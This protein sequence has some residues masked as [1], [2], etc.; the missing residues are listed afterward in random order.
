MALTLA[1]RTPVFDRRVAGLSG[2]AIK[3]I[4][5]WAIYRVHRAVG[6][7]LIGMGGISCAE[8]ALEFLL[9]GATAVALGTH[10]FA[11]P[12]APPALIEDLERWCCHN[13]IDDI[14]ELRGMLI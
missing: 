7:P 13:E 9:A 11:D 12:C 2:P 8:D 6:L 5:L 10:L 14:N 1:T 3:P 4:A